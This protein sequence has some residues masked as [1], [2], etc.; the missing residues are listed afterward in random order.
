ME[1]RSKYN[2]SLRLRCADGYTISYMHTNSQGTQVRLC[3]S[4]LFGAHYQQV[5]GDGK[6]FP[7]LHEARKYA[8]DRGYLE[9]Y[10]PKEKKD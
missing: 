3:A 10:V 5:E 4:R 1:I 8:Y 9:T 7:S 6:S 2:P